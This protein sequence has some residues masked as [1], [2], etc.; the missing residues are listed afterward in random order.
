MQTDRVAGDP[1]EPNGVAPL[2]EAIQDPSAEVRISAF[3]AV[4][5]LPLPPPGLGEDRR[6]RQMGHGF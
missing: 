2:L 5:R 6:L 4:T 3:E 1:L